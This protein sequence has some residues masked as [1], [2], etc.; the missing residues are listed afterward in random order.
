MG[1]GW[2]R[3]L[4][5]KV[6]HNNP[7][8][9][10]GHLGMM[11]EWH[12]ATPTRDERVFPFPPPSQQPATAKFNGLWLT[13]KGNTLVPLVSVAPDENKDV[14]MIISWPRLPATS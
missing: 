5:V 14:V 11:M 10:F 7:V 6:N 2:E 8:Q 12:A 1:E 3:S 9:S 4:K 13:K